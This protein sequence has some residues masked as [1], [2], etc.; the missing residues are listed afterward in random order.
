VTV[1]VQGPCAIALYVGDL[2]EAERA[3]ALLLD[4]SAKPALNTWNALGRCYQGRL[5]LAR[6]DFAGLPVLRTALDWLRAAGFAL[7]YAISLGAL[8]EGL[9]AAGQLA[10]AHTAIGEAL[11]RAESNEEHWCMPELLRIKGE[12]MRS[13]GSAT[14][15]AVEDCFR[16]ALDWA[17]R[18][19]ALSWEL[20]AA[21]SLA[22]LWHQNGKTAEAHALLSAVYGRFTEGFDTADLKAACAL[23]DEL[24]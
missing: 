1:L 3:I 6:G 4:Y 20:R 8:A 9:A 17:R 15:D 22:K 14:T 12:I 19:G 11:E 7:R 5:L 13:D 23:M 21:T 18:Q 10:E 24:R 16:Q 2:A